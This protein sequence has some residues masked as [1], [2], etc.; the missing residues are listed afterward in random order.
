MYILFYMY[1]YIF[2]FLEHDPRKNEW[3]S[4]MSKGSRRLSPPHGQYW[5]RFNCFILFM[6]S[7]T[8]EVGEAC[9]LDIWT[10]I[11]K[12]PKFKIK[13]LADL[14]LGEGNPGLQTAACSLCA[15]MVF[16]LYVLLESS[17]VSSGKGISSTMGTLPLWLNL[18]LNISSSPTSKYYH[19]VGYGFNTKILRELAHSVYTRQQKNCN[20]VQKSRNDQQDEIQL[21]FTQ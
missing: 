11:T 5:L 6:N 3:T 16:P 19:I 15:L 20:Q 12:Y 13:V 21:L 4:V 14:A 7:Q 17:C 10:A 2:I 9:E 18:N 8:G 1:F